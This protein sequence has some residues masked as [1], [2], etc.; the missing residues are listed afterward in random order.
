MALVMSFGPD[1]SKKCGSDLQLVKNEWIFFIFR[2]KKYLTINLPSSCISASISRDDFA[3]R[4]LC[5]YDTPKSTPRKVGSLPAASLT[6]NSITPSLHTPCKQT[7][8]GL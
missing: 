4:H 5:F 8:M 2:A 7:E 1:K 6:F 3:R